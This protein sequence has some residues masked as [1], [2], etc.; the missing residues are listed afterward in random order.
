MNT[1]QEPPLITSAAVTPFDLR[2]LLVA[3]MACTMAMMA[4]VSLIGPIARVL[5]LAAW[6]AGTA[7]TV[8][9]VIW[10]LLARA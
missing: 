3:N 6:Q 10:M 7:V 4:F 8:A 9:G 1:A 2:P 5:G